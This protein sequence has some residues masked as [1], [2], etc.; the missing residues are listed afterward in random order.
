MIN[1]GGVWLVDPFTGVIAGMNLAEA[2]TSLPPDCNIDLA[3]QLLI[4]AEA[5][6]CNASNAK[7]ESKGK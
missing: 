4:A 5:P 6:Y 2:L 7:L 1:R 3:K